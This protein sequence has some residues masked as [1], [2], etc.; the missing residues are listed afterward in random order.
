MKY[1][2]Q[3]RGR[4][5]PATHWVLSTRMVMDFSETSGIHHFMAFF[6]REYDFL[7]KMSGTLF[8]RNPTYH[9]SSLTPSYPCPLFLE[10]PDFNTE[11]DSFLFH[12][13]HPF[14]LAQVS[15]LVFYQFLQIKSNQTMYHWI[16]STLMV[17]DFSETPGIHHFMAFISWFL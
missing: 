6:L 9:M 1:S 15:L 10:S 17:M 5:W 7:N 11:N 4:F 13:S 12:N 14:F 2:N 16:L 8:Q 3:Q